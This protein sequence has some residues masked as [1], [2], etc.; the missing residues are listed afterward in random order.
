MKAVAVAL[1]AVASLASYV[2]LVGWLKT[3]YFLRPFGLSPAALGP[4]W[5]ESAFQ[6]WYVVQ[7]LVYF[8]WIIWLVVQTRRFTFA[9]V[10]VV[11]SLIPLATH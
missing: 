6:S 4:G 7:N 5:V 9:L 8:T 10:A 2:A 3:V 11:Y 1:A